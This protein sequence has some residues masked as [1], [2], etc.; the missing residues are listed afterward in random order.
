[1]DNST[2][3]EDAQ[4]PKTPEQ[5]AVKPNDQVEETRLS[6]VYVPS[7]ITALT[8]LLMSFIISSPRSGKRSRISSLSPSR[9]IPG[10]WFGSPKS[11]GEGRTS[12][13]TATGQFVAARGSNSDELTVTT[14]DLTASQPEVAEHSASPSATR[15]SRCTIM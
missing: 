4:L 8:R 11:A 6:P 7:A 10:G 14:D 5:A 1:M 3:V 2:N 15:K 12:L 9:F 13:E